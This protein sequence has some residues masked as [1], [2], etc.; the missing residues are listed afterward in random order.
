MNETSKHVQGTPVW[1][2]LASRDVDAIKVFYSELLG[3]EWQDLMSSPQGVFSQ[4]QLGD[5]VVAGV[6][7]YREGMPLP[8]GPLN[9]VNAFWVD[10]A[11]AAMDRAVEKGST[12]L[13]PACDDPASGG[14]KSLLLTPEGAPFVV[15]SGDK[16]IENEAW[17]DLGAVCWVEYYTRD[18]P[19]INDFVGHVFGSRYQRVDLTRPPTDF[20]DAE[21]EI[22][23]E[24]HWL[25]IDGVE[26]DRGGM[27][28]MD[29]SWETCHLTSWSTSTSR[30]ATHPRL[31][32]QSWEARSVC[33]PRRYRRASFQSSMT[34]WVQ[35]LAL[36]RCVR[37]SDNEKKTRHVECKFN[38]PEAKTPSQE[39]QKQNA[40]NRKLQAR[41]TLVGR[42]IDLGPRGGEK[43]LRHIVRLGI[44]RQRCG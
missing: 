19:G 44:R 17:G 32:Q 21:G 2:D 12:V 18:I 28:E 30:T 41:D 7:T 35:L 16:G 27:M 29:E 13:M 34:L 43:F 26:P 38:A 22:A 31:G 11:D 10:D 5:K 40:K 37:W 1:W 36:C 4:A 20:E 42:S 14:R 9:W 6:Y 25:K 23:Y 8:E 15:W 3:W 39:R 33:H 24:Y